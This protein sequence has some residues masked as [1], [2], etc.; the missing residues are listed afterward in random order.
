M[1]HG[2]WTLRLLAD[3][4]VELCLGDSISHE[5]VGQVLKKTSRS[6]TVSSTGAWGR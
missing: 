6:P 5:T 2:R 1:G 4:A 3:Q